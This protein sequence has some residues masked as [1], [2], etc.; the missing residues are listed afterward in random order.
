M[1]PQ[2]YELV[3][4]FSSVETGAQAF[5]CRNTKDKF[6]VLAFRGTELS[7]KDI[8]ADVK[9][10]LVEAQIGDKKFEMHSGYLKQFQSLQ[11]QIVA[12]LNGPKL[13]NYQLFFTGHSL[14]GA[15]AITATRFLA[16]D[17]TGACY[18]F[19]SPPVGTAAFDI[20]ITTPIYR[21]INH[22]DIVPRLPNPTLIFVI[23]YSAMLVR[24]VLDTVGGFSKTIRE[25]TW[26]KKCA[27][28]LSDAQKYRQSGYGS[29]LV[30]EGSSTRLRYSVGSFDRFIWWLKQWA[31]LWQ[32]EF[33]LLSDHSI[34]AYSKKLAIWASYRQ[35][36][37]P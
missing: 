2:G 5:M 10:N 36:Q 18:T 3:D 8:K 16:N 13:K 33:K 34:E 26:Y 23:R 22:V 37:K 19:G 7:L 28:L 32:G 31:N 29:Y 35:Q 11:S 21:I 9:A 15:L 6:A 30:G 14:G 17:G 20:D 4:T 25:S 12:T 1:K 24:I 27:Q